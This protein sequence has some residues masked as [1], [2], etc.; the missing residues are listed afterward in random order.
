MASPD[1]AAAPSLP[2]RP[3]RKCSVACPPARVLAHLRARDPSLS[4]FVLEN[5]K[6]YRRT[7]E[8]AA[9]PLAHLW[10]SRSAFPGGHRLRTSPCSPRGARAVGFSRPR[11]GAAR[12]PPLRARPGPARSL[13]RVDIWAKNAG[14]VS[15]LFAEL[16]GRWAPGSAPKT[17]AS[18]LAGSGRGHRR[19]GALRETVTSVSGA[20]GAGRPLRGAASP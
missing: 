3:V 20:G 8:I 17:F 4:G 1:S 2:K 19:G 9:T 6:N 10:C 16:A 11:R 5:E 13:S 18:W 7:L 15:V 14:L 12:L